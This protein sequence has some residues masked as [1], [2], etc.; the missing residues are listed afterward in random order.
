MFGDALGQSGIPCGT[1]GMIGNSEI[2]QGDVVGDGDV[3]S[4]AF[5]VHHEG[6]DSERCALIHPRQQ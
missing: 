5:P 2:H 3:R 6:H 4:A 1:V